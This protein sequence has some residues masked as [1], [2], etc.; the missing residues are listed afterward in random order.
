MFVKILK[1]LS[2]SFMFVFLVFLS[3]TV[4]AIIN[5]FIGEIM[6]VRAGGIILGALGI[7]TVKLAWDITRKII[8]RERK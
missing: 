6:G 1:T 8:K 2:F 4:I 3:W 7:F 5:V